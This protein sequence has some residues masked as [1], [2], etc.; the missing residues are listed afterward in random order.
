MTKARSNLGNSCPSI[1]DMDTARVTGRVVR[2]GQPVPVRADNHVLDLKTVAPQV[3][4][5]D[6]VI[7]DHV[8]DLG[9]VALQVLCIDYVISGHVLHLERVAPQVFSIDHVASDHVLT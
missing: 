5:I 9:T 8:L 6:H 4:S 1:S 2:A 3:L 7:F